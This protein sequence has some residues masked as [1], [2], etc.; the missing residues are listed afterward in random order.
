MEQVHRPLSVVSSRL[1]IT[2]NHWPLSCLTP[3]SRLRTPETQHHPVASEKRNVGLPMRYK[4]RLRARLPDVRL[5]GEPECWG[6]SCTRRDSASTAGGTPCRCGSRS[7]PDG[8]ARFS[9]APYPQ[10]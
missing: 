8:Q 3:D 2:A 10:N 5:E 4:L 1:P 7:T 6:R 9:P